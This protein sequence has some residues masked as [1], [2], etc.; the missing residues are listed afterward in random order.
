[1]AAFIWNYMNIFVVIIS[2]GISSRLK[3]LNDE[4]ERVKGEVP[5]PYTYFYDE[6]RWKHSI[7]NL[8]KQSLSEDYWEY[9]RSQYRSIVELCEIVDEEVS[10][11]TI[12]ALANN[13]FFVCVQLMKSLRWNPWV[14]FCFCF[15]ILSILPTSLFSNQAIAICCTRGLLLV[16]FTFFNNT[17]FGISTF[18]FRYSRWIKTACWGIESSSQKGMVYRSRKI[19]RRGGQWYT[20]LNRHAVLL[21]D[22][23]AY[24]KCKLND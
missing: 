15:C 16:F 23:K 13:L 12:I 18:R 8:L 4:L 11:I 22:T 3:Q 5:Q 24:V 1:M 7:F 14:P 6:E 17:D 10:P 21:H 2:I 20:F 9:R 19:H